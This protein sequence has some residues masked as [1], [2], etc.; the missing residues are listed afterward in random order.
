MTVILTIGELLAVLSGILG[1]FGV[2]VGAI[3]GLTLHRIT[4]LQE[5]IH[6]LAL[7]VARLRGQIGRESEHDFQAQRD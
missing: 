5:Q 4:A 3:L 2:T 6:K 7:E 1:A